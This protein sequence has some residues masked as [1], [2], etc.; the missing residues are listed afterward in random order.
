M[1]TRVCACLALSA[2]R[3]NDK[4]GLI[5]FSREVD[6][7]VPA[8]QGRPPRAAHRARLPRAAGRHDA[9]T[10]LAPA[11]EFAAR[12]IRRRAIVFV[13]S[14]FLA[15]G[16]EEALRRCARRHDVIAVRLLAPELDPPADRG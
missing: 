9:G 13:V 10:D 16:W 2:V 15:D 14:D 3:N 12:V 6:R 11:L 4:V 7:Y 5:A 8:A 1:A